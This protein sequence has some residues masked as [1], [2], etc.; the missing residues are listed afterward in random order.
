MLLPAGSVWPSGNLPFIP[1]FSWCVAAQGQ[2]CLGPTVLSAA[3]SP[4]AV[5]VSFLNLV[6]ILL[7]HVFR[8]AISICSSSAFAIH[9]LFFISVSLYVFNFLLKR[10][11]FT[12]SN[13]ITLSSWSAVRLRGLAF[14]FF[15]DCYCDCDCVSD[16]VCYWVSS[17]KSNSSRSGCVKG[18]WGLAGLPLFH[19]FSGIIKWELDPNCGSSNWQLETD[20]GGVDWRSCGVSLT[21]N[22]KINPF[23]YC[24]ACPLTA[25]VIIHATLVDSR[26][27]PTNDP[28]SSVEH[29][30]FMWCTLHAPRYHWH[31]P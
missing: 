6:L 10:Y 22:V 27:Q 28:V 14:F 31:V 5:L 23:L 13:S 26:A 4:D 11:S 1:W 9:N 18:N 16:C 25:Y 7:N 19:P 3:P 21:P 29:P 24:P 30:L 8:T 17:W 20:T 2:N 15:L 12:F